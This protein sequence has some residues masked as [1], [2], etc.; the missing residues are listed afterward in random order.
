MLAGLSRGQSVLRNQD[1]KFKFKIKMFIKTEDFLLPI[2]LT[3][4]IIPPVN[5]WKWNV[6]LGG[7]YLNWENFL[8]AKN[9]LRKSG[10]QIQ[11]RNE[12]NTLEP[13]LS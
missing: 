4:E 8:L 5:K 11:F 3:C 1:T 10:Y 12:K 13:I 2:L 6:I 7:S 9:D